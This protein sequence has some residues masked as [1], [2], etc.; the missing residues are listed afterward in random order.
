MEF[1]QR[2]VGFHF[3]FIKTSLFL[4]AMFYVA[5]DVSSLKL[6]FFSSDEENFGFPRQTIWEKN[7]HKILNSL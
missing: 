4:F 7:F 5:S 2:G 1:D 6:G 3:W